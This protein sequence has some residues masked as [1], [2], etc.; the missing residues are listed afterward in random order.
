MSKAVASAGTTAVRPGT[1]LARLLQENPALR[2]GQDDYNINVTANYGDRLD[3]SEVADAL[4]AHPG[5]GRPAHLYFHVP[6]C[7]YICHFCNYVKRKVPGGA[8]GERASR[9]WTDLLLEESGRRLA[10]AP[11]LADARIE[12]VYLGGGTASLLGTEQLGRLVAH[13]RDNY[14]L[15]DD[16]EISLEGNP[17]NF[18]HDE[19]AEACAIGFNRFSVGVQ[20]LQSEVNAFAGR[21]HDAEMSLRAIEKLRATGRPFNVDMMFGLPHQTPAKVADDIRR[22]TDLEVPTIT[23][24]RLRNADRAKM[25]IGNRALWNVESV[26]DRLREEHAFPG[27]DETYEMREAIVE[28]LLDAGYHPSPCGWWNRPGI[29]PEGNIPRVSRNKWQRHDSMIAYGPGAYGWLTGDDD[30]VVQTHNIADIGGY[31][32]LIQNGPELPLA[33]GRRLVGL[34]AIGLVLGFNF[35]ANQ[36][37]DAA[38]FRRRFGVELFHDEPFA[39]VFDELLERGLV[40][41][42]PGAAES[43]VPTLDGE[44]LHEEIISVYFH[45]RIGSFAEAVCRR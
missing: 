44:A 34:E 36:P 3:P 16:C 22:L 38:R 2:I 4:R 18:Q 32:R 39:G 30:T 28:L 11:W 5:A 17:D 42:V 29:Y 7:A 43:V 19:L 6:L 9:V 24:Y 15:T 14:A 1:G 35:K 13:M 37:I 41:P 31:A 27:L 10:H 12:S 20:S 21:G 25:G 33:F 40:E 8:E 23:I 26:R 45:Q